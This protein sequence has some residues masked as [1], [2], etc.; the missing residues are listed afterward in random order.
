MDTVHPILGYS[1]PADFPTDRYVAAT[2]YVARIQS[3]D[4]QVIYRKRQ[5]ML[6]LSGVAFRFRL[7][8]ESDRAY[9]TL[10][11]AFG[12]SPP[13]D[14]YVQRA[15]HFFVFF[16][17]GQA[18]LESLAYGVHAMLAVAGKGKFEI[19]TLAQQ[20]DVKMVGTAKLLKSQLPDAPIG[21]SLARLVDSSEFMRWQGIRNLVT[22]RHHPGET[23]LVHF[24]SDPVP[25]KLMLHQLTT[26]R[27]KPLED[28]VED[29][30]LDQNTMPTFRKW[31]ACQLV[32]LMDDTATLAESLFGHLP[33]PG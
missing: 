6:G 8:A 15:N 11:E 18:S 14:Q 30:V 32:T 20:Q 22:H 10:V 9:T 27:K 23:I 24:G 4:K 7:C 29:L 33:V 1:L 21:K 16:N 13:E 5:C 31:L 28:L 17:A 26:K 3:D 2:K 12:T 25:A 19:D